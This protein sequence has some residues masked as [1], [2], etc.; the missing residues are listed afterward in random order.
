[1]RKKTKEGERDEKR[2]EIAKK[3]TLNGVHYKYMHASLVSVKVSLQ[4]YN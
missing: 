2:G 1:M 3:K 4:S